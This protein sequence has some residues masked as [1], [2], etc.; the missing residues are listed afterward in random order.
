M[1]VKESILYGVSLS[2]ACVIYLLPLRHRENFLIRLI[3]LGVG[4]AVLMSS[5]CYRLA[6]RGAGAEWS[7]IALFAAGYICAVLMTFVCTEMTGFAVWYCAVWEIM[8]CMFVLEGSEFLLYL[9]DDV[10]RNGVLFLSGVLFICAVYGLVALTT[11][12]WMPDDRQ[13][14]IGP[15]QMGSAWVLCIMFGTL[16]VFVHDEETNLTVNLM[17][18]FYCITLL[19]L[20]NTLFKKSSMRKELEMIQLLWHQ[21]KSQYQISKETIDLINRKCHDL[22]H[23]VRALRTLSSEEEKEKQISEIEDSVGIYSAIVHTGNEILDVI[24]SEKSLRC[25][26]REIHINCVAD[27]SLLS[28][29]NPVDLYTLFGNA[30]DNAIEAVQKLEGETAREID[31]MIYG[32]SGLLMIEIVNPVP[33]E[34]RFEN[35]DPLTTKHEKGF[36]GFGVK[37]MRHTVE[38]YGGYLTAEVKD[39]C[40]YLKI[41][42]P[43]P[44]EVRTAEGEEER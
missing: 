33:G 15:K 40:F 25:E 12:R 22:K 38:K 6:W 24:L 13:Y 19:Y 41:M 14:R 26:D 31:I 17:L 23:Q 27:G 8:T 39:G 2:G 36:H 9:T 42:I 35:G 29:M 44:E 34:V 30:V 43:L 1:G 28:F 3:L 18:Q 7:E 16:C 5:L 37:S 4:T 32:K 10:E 11:A 21:Q 20:Q